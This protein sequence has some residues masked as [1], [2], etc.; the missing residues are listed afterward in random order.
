MLLTFMWQGEK[1]DIEKAELIRRG[2]TIRTKLKQ[3]Q[4]YYLTD[5]WNCLLD[6]WNCL[7]DEWNCLSG[8]VFE[9]E[10][11]FSGLKGLEVFQPEVITVEL[12]Y[13]MQY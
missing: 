5:E 7:P 3:L 13:F 9:V 4:V 10:N 8:R 12:L 6:E 1:L 11:Y 2:K